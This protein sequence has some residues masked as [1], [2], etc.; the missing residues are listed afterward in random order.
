MGPESLQ[1]LTLL[2]RCSGPKDGAVSC[3]RRV[4]WYLP[5][6]IIF[7]CIRLPNSPL[8]R[9]AQSDP[10]QTSF[11][12]LDQVGSVER[13]LDRFIVIPPPD[14]LSIHRPGVASPSESIFQN[15]LMYLAVAGGTEGTDQQDISSFL[16][17]FDSTAIHLPRSSPSRTRSTACGPPS[18]PKRKLQLLDSWQ[19]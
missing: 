12:K 10:S 3:L 2:S 4:D 17:S 16:F 18:C 6:L 5:H 11:R 8:F 9:V 13:P 14:P 1:D 7:R 19:R 15:R